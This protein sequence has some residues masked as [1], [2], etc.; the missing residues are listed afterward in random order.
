MLNIKTDSRKI[1]PGDTFVAIKEMHNDGHD[2]INDAINNG[3]KRIVCEHG[4]YP[5]DTLIVPN[6][7]EYL[8]N[9]LYD[10]YYDKIS[11]MTLIGLTGT[12]GKTTTCYLIYQ[13]LNVLFLFLI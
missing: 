6:S 12:N 2:Y 9:Y 10:N 8:E 5:V 1:K 3:A 7:R 13:M 11:T 4:N